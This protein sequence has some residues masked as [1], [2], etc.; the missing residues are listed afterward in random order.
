METLDKP[1]IDPCEN[2]AK[3]AAS[4]AMNKVVIVPVPYAGDEKPIKFTR[5]PENRFMN[6]KPA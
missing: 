3:I 4:S 2:V 5:P 1:V 6:E